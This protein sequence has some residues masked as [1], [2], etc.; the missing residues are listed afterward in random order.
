[1]VEHASSV[2]GIY[3]RN[4][5]NNSRGQYAKRVVLKGIMNME[6][7]GFLAARWAFRIRN[8][9]IR[10]FNTLPSGARRR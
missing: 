8:N 5:S 9:D 2:Q 7:V 10:P 1:M 3:D 6:Q 4:L